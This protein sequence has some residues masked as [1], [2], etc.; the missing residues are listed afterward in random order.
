M[1]SVSF[2]LLS[3]LLRIRSLNFL[4]RF[5]YTEL[6]VS[7][8]LA[9]MI[10]FNLGVGNECSTNFENQF[11]QSVCETFNANMRREIFKCCS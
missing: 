1:Q 9:A 6:T 3:E 10:R 4:Y 2:P 7:F 8:F 11:L 5:N